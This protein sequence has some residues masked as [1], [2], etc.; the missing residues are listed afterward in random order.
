M[1]V[2]AWTNCANVRA[3]RVGYQFS[4]TMQGPTHE[5]FKSLFG[6]DVTSP[7]TFS[8]S[9]SFDTAVPGEAAGVGVRRYSQRIDRGFA[10]NL[11]SY[12]LQLAASEYHVIV[13]NDY[14]SPAADVLTIEYVYD[15]SNDVTP[16]RILVGEEPWTGNF[17]SI[18]ISLNWDSDPFS[19]PDEPK[20]TVDKPGTPNAAITAA[21]TSSGPP[22]F[23]NSLDISA[24]SPKPGDYNRNSHLDF[25]DQIEWRRVFGETGSASL[26][27]DGDN[28]GAVDA[29]DYVVWRNAL[30]SVENAANVPEPGYLGAITLWLLLFWWRAWP[31]LRGE[32]QR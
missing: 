8:G 4:G 21:A 28:S 15:L 13:A 26:Y 29:G 25:S 27:A 24:I 31:W 5:L 18:S 10:L 1:L 6:V 22:R 14:G 12:P 17:A 11:T 30:N 23:F 2:A 9:F 16:E 7:D 20:L 32:R 3:E 19:E